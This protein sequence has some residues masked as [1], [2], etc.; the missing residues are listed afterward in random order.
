MK[1]RISTILIIVVLIL[2]S[3][4]IIMR[5]LFWRFDAK[6]DLLLKIPIRTADSKEHTLFIHETSTSQVDTVRRQF[7]DLKTGVTKV[8]LWIDNSLDTTHFSIIGRY[9]SEV[10]DLALSNDSSTQALL[11]PNTEHGMPTGWGELIYLKADGSLIHSELVTPHIGD[12][13]KDGR[14]EVYDP[15]ANTYSKLNPAT[16]T[17][18]K[19]DIKIDTTRK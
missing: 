8:S 3:S 17:W 11:I 18:V 9:Y 2:F 15:R 12:A 6:L 1:S 19:V 5:E 4:F 7:V 13:D 16:G 10:R 14:L